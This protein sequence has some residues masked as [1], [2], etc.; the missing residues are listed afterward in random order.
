MDIR[1]SE[2]HR[3]SESKRATFA[4]VPM[5][6]ET[7]GQRRRHLGVAEDA[8]PFAESQIDRDGHRRSPI[9]AADEV[10]RKLSASLREKQVAELV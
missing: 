2:N 4:K 8:R 3:P 6:N 10:E 5:M 9:E 7:I 1:L